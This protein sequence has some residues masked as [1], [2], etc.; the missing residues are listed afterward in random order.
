[1][2]PDLTVLLV[3][4]DGGW[5]AGR[6]LALA[7]SGIAVAIILRA[8]RRLRHTTLLAPGVWAIASLVAVMIGVAGSAAENTSAAEHIHYL[9]AVSTLA[10]FVALLGAKRPQNRAWQWIVAALLLLLALQS[11]KAIVIDRGAPPALHSA[12]R[13]LLAILLV[14]ELLNY[15]PTTSAP[16][17]GLVLA[18]QVFLLAQQL[19]GAAWL[20]E[21][22]GSWGLSLL[23]AG[24]LAAAV[25]WQ[26]RPRSLVAPASS[27]DA[28]ALDR[29]WR[30]FRDAY[31]ALWALRVAERINTTSR[32]HGWPTRLRWRGFQ[33]FKPERPNAAEEQESAAKLFRA[34]L[35]RF[36]ST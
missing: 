17:A 29:A 2:A 3:S 30:G 25:V 22:R 24:V 5:D 27:D 35:T 7:A 11:L 10:P 8:C 20:P 23:S 21:P 18:G 12:W 6:C 32:Q 13:W 16:A 1:M 31:G 26:L 36:L 14:A 19:P 4:A 28:A 15:L 33:S 34:M 9:A